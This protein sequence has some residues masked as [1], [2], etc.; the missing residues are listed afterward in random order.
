L[1]PVQ[2]PDRLRAALERLIVE[3]GL[4]AKFGAAGRQRAL[5]CYDERLV[6]ARQL[7]AL[8]LMPEELDGV[9]VEFT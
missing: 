4:R 7:R 8:G 5:R 9:S 2:Q 1:V 6:I 3:P